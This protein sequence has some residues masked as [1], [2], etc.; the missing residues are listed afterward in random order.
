MILND[1]FEEN[2]RKLTLE[3]KVGKRN[4]MITIDTTSLF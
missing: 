3:V 2:S 1:T 4:T